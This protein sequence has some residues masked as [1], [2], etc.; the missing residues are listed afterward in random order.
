MMM[1]R[2]E[3]TTVGCLVTAMFLA[4]CGGG[5]GGGGSAPPPTTNTPPAPTPTYTVG[6]SVSGL[7]GTL[8]LQNNGGNNLTV[9]A[10]GAFTFTQSLTSGATYNVTIASQ[11]SGQACTLAS[12]TGSATGNVTAVTITCANLYTVGGS[13][14]DLSGSLVLRNNGGNDLTVSGNGGFTFTQSLTSGAAYDVAI[15]AQP[16][17]QACAVANAQGTVASNVTSVTITCT[18]LYTLGGNVSGLKGQMVLSRNAGSDLVIAG[19]GPFAFTTP[20]AAGASYAVSISSHSAL[21]ICNISNG[22]GTATANVSNIVVD[23]SDRAVTA[24]LTYQPIKTFHFTWSAVPGATHYRLLEDPDGSSGFVQAGANL[25]ANVSSHDH[26]APLHARVNARYVVQACDASICIDSNT[27]AVDVTQLTQAIGYFKASNTS[28]D[29][30]F[31]DSIALAADGTT[32]AVGNWGEDSAATGINGDQTNNPASAQNRGAVYVFTRSGLSWTQQAYLKPSNISNGFDLFGM[33]I[34]LSANGNRL[35]VGA[36]GE[37]SGATGINGDQTDKS[38]SFSGAVYAFTRSGTTWTQEAYIKASNTDAGDQF[39]QA[40]ALSADGETLAVGAI[41]EQSMATGINGNQ[42]DDFGSSNGAV[43][44]F[45]HATGAWAQQAYIKG[46]NTYVTNQFGYALKLSADGST[47]AVGTPFEGTLTTGIN[48]DESNQTSYGAGAVYTFVRTAGN[49]S[50]QAY[51]KASN[52]NLD[53]NF[54]WTLALA[55]DGNTLAV[56]AWHEDSAATGIDG[57]QADNLAT[58]SGAVYVFT[59]NSTTWAQQAYLKSNNTL[60]SQAFGYSVALSGDGNRLA[61]GAMGDGSTAIGLNGDYTVGPGG[62]YGAAYVFERSAGVWT[63]QTYVKASNTNMGDYFGWVVALS[64][65]GDSLAVTA[66]GED[67]M[68]TGVDGNQTNDPV[69]YFDSGAVYLY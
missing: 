48:G 39:G 12:A 44:V 52:T 10:S 13:V 65:D 58:E 5:G 38:A 66:E 15:A 23:C 20:V 1:L 30:H 62:H 53:D 46:S 41:T 14:T 26:V 29:N 24:A 32:M 4:A 28:Q 33:S 11:P 7:A 47:L 50:Q 60:A 3:R 17:G 55:A 22:G 67:S 16:A 57:D 31:G 37:A 69:T 40:V 9:S 6:G 2:R 68:S 19:N 63:Q 64:S 18:D 61:V 34:G 56:G 21:Q 27:L 54:G 42:A 35:V 43:Y 25:A 45:T 51:I 59:R 8:V 36:P 49:W